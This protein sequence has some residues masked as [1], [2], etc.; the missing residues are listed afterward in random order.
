[1]DEA[2]YIVMN[3]RVAVETDVAGARELAFK[4]YEAMGGAEFFH[5]LTQTFYRLVSK[6]EL[7]GPMFAGDWDEHARRLARHFNRMYGTPDLTEAWNPQFLRAH[8]N[9]VIAQRHRLRWIALM[10]KAGEEI[11]AAQPYFED[12]MLVMLMSA[13]TEVSGASRGAALAR[14][15]RLNKMGDLIES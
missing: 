3:N 2:T 8:L 9:N 11:S 6:D 14:G 15:Q 5:R 12:F 7:I 4:A 13:S 10:A 1:V